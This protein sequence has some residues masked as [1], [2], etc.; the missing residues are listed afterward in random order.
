M[1]NILVLA[2]VAFLQSCSATNP[3]T[4]A[5]KLVEVM[6]IEDALKIQ[7]LAPDS[8][9]VAPPPNKAACLRRES[10]GVMTSAIAAA[11]QRE[12]TPEDITYLIRF[13]ESSSGRKYTKKAVVTISRQ[14]GVPTEEQIPVYAREDEQA[15][16]DF[17]QSDAG[18]KITTGGAARAM[19]LAIF[20]QSAKITYRCG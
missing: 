5:V 1:R 13:Y 9:G 17:V 3:S 16:A 14:L 19:S 11:F 4:D 15:I 20:E 12:L 10:A 2:V 6:Q 18:R 8:H 7:L